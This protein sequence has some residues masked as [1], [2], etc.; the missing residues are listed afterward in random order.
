MSTFPQAGILTSL[1]VDS[2]E[3]KVAIPLFNFETDWCPIST[4]LLYQTD[5][6][7]SNVTLQNVQIGTV[8]SESGTIESLKA[9]KIKFSTL[10]VGD[11][12]LLT[13]LNGDIHRPIV[14]AR[15]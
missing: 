15:L 12:V 1:N 10:K 2:A 3:A 11:E 6:E 13:F 14:V 5:V 4:H 9:E 7:L 8:S